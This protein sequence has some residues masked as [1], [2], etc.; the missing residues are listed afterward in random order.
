MKKPSL[1]ILNTR[2]KNQSQ[3][4]SAQLKLMGVD[5]VELPLIEIQ[6]VPVKEKTFKTDIAI[7]LSA[8]AV[9]HFYDQATLQAERIIAIGSSTTQALESHGCKNTQCPKVFSS[10]GLLEM[11]ELQNVH[12]KKIMIVSGENSK[13]LLPHGLKLRGAIVQNVISYRRNPLFYDERALVPALQSTHIIVTSSEIFQVLLDLFEAHHAWLVQRTLC[14]I[15]DEMKR[16]AEHLG[17]TS[18]IQARNATT[19]AIIEALDDNRNKQT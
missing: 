6:S 11:P 2:P 16:H 9:D 7:F 1:I 5:V 12:H 17:F 13:G 10:E 8:N 18:V 15:S 19:E 4:L 3:A 14:V